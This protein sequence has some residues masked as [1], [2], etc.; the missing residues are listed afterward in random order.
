MEYCLSVL[1]GKYISL[2]TY[3]SKEGVWNKLSQL[4]AERLKGESDQISPTV[5]RRKEIL[6]IRVEINEIGN[7]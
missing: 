2:N 6:K 1:W 4:L 3:I 7:G 5:R